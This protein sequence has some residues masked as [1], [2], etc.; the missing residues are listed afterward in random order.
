MH[1]LFVVGAGVST[2]FKL[3]AGPALQDQIRIFLNPTNNRAGDYNIETAR[4]TSIVQDLGVSADEQFKLYR[5]ISE[6]LPLAN[7]ID[8]FLEK[9][10]QDAD[11]LGFIGKY[12]ITTLISRAEAS[13]SLNEAKKRIDFGELSKTWLGKL[14]PLINRSGAANIHPDGISEV[15]F[16]TFNYDRC[17][18]QFFYLAFREL[19]RIS[20][21]EAMQIVDLIDIHHVYGSLGD[22]FGRDDGLAYGADQ[23]SV[24]RINAAKKIRTF[25]EQEEGYE[26][27]RIK[28]IIDRA[29]R[30]VFLG[31]SFLPINQKVLTFEHK[32]SS[33]LKQVLGTCFGMDQP[34]V[35]RAQDWV[36]TAFRKGHAGTRL[37]DVTGSGFF[38]ENRLLFS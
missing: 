6:A 23:F 2:D 1:T 38:K 28:T 3:P 19:C 33:K 12:A 31:F 17:I 22:P 24:E 21:S 25:S 16:L 29:D 37:S 20:P 11:A 30:I 34:D 18:E 27:K 35:T 36:D 32:G 15:S 5:W 9:N 8:D 7:S 13:S 26:A 14:F 10:K 4:I